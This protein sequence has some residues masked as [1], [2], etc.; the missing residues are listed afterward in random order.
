M[1]KRKNKNNQRTLYFGT[2]EKIKSVDYFYFCV[3]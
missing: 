1:L 3:T 2:T